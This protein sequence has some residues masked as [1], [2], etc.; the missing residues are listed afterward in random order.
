MRNLNDKAKN[1]APLKQQP[2]AEWSAKKG[3]A[4]NSLNTHK[5]EKLLEIMRLN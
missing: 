1:E 4:R 3:E 5:K 2:P